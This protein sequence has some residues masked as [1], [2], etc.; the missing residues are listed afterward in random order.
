MSNRCSSTESFTVEYVR[1]RTGTAQA[2]FVYFL[3]CESNE[4]FVQLSHD[5]DIISMN[6]SVF[7]NGGGDTVNL[8][9]QTDP[10]TTT[11]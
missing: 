4:N 3:T 11:K 10:T 9:I 2:R 5:E 1:S 7:A 8:P 6:V